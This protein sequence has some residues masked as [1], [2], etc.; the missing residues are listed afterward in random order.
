MITITLFG[1]TTV[2]TG[3][4]TVVTASSLGGIK[5]RQILELLAL[6]PGTPMSKDKLA[7]LIWDGQPPKTYVATLESYI[8]VLRRSLGLSGGRHSVLATTS[9]GYVLD[10]TRLTVDLDEVRRL[11]ARAA[12]ATPAFA[13]ELTDVALSRVGGVLL[14]SEPYVDWAAAERGFLQQELTAA[15]T[16]AAGQALD[17]GLLDQAVRLAGAAVG[18][19]PLLERPVQVLMQALWQ[20]GRR[21][22]ALRAY[23]NLRSATVEELGMEPGPLTYELYMGI[24]RAD[25]A[26]GQGA[27]SAGRSELKL[28]LGLLRQT[29]ES[30]PVIDLPGADRVLA[31]LAVQTL[32]VA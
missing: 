17:S 1:P 20:S 9:H 14:A 24:L 21:T 2:R 10:P 11:L 19:D 15:C 16:R 5:P 27:P 3:S 8:C 4:G 26:A 18:R 30:M 32:D 29:L 12:T 22:E 7:D 25:G 6:S 13:V 23:A 31:A 28:L